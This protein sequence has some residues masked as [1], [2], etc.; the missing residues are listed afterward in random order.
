MVELVLVG[1]SLPPMKEG[2]M[3]VNTASCSG[4]SPYEPQPSL[5]ADHG[6]ECHWLHSLI[7][8]AFLGVDE[9]SGYLPGMAREAHH[10]HTHL[11][12]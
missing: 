6:L 7:H 4:E 1:G 12:T 5:V 9:A 8:A 2:G 3:I 10:L 11:H